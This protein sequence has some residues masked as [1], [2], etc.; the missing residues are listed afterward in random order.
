MDKR[1]YDHERLAAA[2]KASGLS[3]IEIARRCDVERMTIYRALRGQSVSY[4]I[5]DAIGEIVGL[6]V[7]SI[8]RGRSLAAKSR[9]NHASY[10]P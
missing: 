6:P 5:V 2:V 7:T 8:L 1:H 3:V 4:D 10:V 9:E